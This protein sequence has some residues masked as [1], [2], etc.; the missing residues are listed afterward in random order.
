MARSKD[1]L[2]L[3]ISEVKRNTGI[4]GD[5]KAKHVD[6]CLYQLTKKIVRLKDKVSKRT[7]KINKKE[8]KDLEDYL[9]DMLWYTVSCIDKLGLDVD[10]VLDNNTQKIQNRWTKNKYYDHKFPKKEQLPRKFSVKFEEIKGK[11][12]EVKIRISVLLSEKSFGNAQYM[13]IGDSI[14]DN[15]LDKDFYRY[16]DV[17]HLAFASHLGWSPITRK[18]L[19]R[20]R[21]SNKEVDRIE[22][23]ARAAITEEAVSAYIFEHRKEEDDFKN[24]VSYDIL[25]TVSY[26][27]RKLEVKNRTFKDWEQAIVNGYTVFN[28]L[29]KNRQGIVTADLNKKKISFKKV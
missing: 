4:F 22:D 17:F 19:K 24:G 14:D 20:K 3:F 12:S 26:L 8:K 5:D 27:T 2:Q 10:T 21:K 18:L 11:G 16:H 13:Q 28:Q 23:G 7:G 6:F 1:S 15:S 29:K 25:K 9:G